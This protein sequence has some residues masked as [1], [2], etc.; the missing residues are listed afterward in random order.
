MSI[1][2]VTRKFQITIPKDV[3][4][5][6]RISVGDLL[7]ITVDNNRI[8]IEPIKATIKDPVEH[9]SSLT[10]EPTDIDAVKLVEESWN[11]D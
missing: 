10:T 5:K 8:I 1:I 7:K 11:E 3:R 4:E 2:K 6:L 9:L